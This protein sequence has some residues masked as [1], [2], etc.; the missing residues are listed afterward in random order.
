MIRD[1]VGKFAQIQVG[2]T[3]LEGYVH[4]EDERYFKLIEHNNSIVIINI[5]DI[6]FVRLENVS[7][8][9]LPIEPEK[10]I[11]EKPAPKQYSMSNSTCSDELSMTLPK[12]SDTHNIPFKNPNFIRETGEKK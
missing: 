6:S 2:N 12:M 7:K 3:L 9:N 1:I 4:S 11:V 8:E 5:D 10:E